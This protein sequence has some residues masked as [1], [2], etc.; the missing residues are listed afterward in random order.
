MRTMLVTGIMLAVVATLLAPGEAMATGSLNVTV[1]P[2]PSTAGTV[3][4]A[5]W[6]LDNDGTWRNPSSTV[7]GLAAG[8]HSVKMKVLTGWLVVENRTVTIVDGEQTKL[9]VTYVKEG[10]A[11]IPSSCGGTWENCFCQ[12]FTDLT[13][14]ETILGLIPPEYL[15]MLTLLQPPNADVNGTSHVDLT[16]NPTPKKSLDVPSVGDPKATYILTTSVKNGANGHGTISPATGPQNAGATITLTATPDPGGY[17]VKEWKGTNDNESTALTNTVTMSSDKTVEVEFYIPPLIQVRGNG[18]TDCNAELALIAAL[19]QNT[20]LDLT[21][22]GGLSHA[23]M[24]AAWQTNMATLASF[25]GSYFG[26]VGFLLPSLPILL[27][28]FLSIGDGS[29]HVSADPADPDTLDIFDVAGSG[30]FI[31]ILMQ[32]LGDADIGADPLLSSLSLYTR[33]GA[34]DGNPDGKDYLSP[35]GDADGDGATNECEYRAYGVAGGYVSKA[36]DPAQHPSKAECDALVPVFRFGSV[37]GGGWRPMGAPIELSVTVIDSVAPVT[38][39]W[40]KNGELLLGATLS[41]YTIADPQLTDSAS[42]SCE[43][44][45]SSP[46]TINTGS[47]PVTVV[48]AGALPVASMLGGAALTAAVALLGGIRLSRRMRK[49]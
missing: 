2:Y 25:V 3:T 17:T 11:A 44:T 39:Q 5:G 45:D 19:L 6:M 30:G 15:G 43:A 16:P 12:A 1:S 34:A 49:A 21:S 10:A 23:K 22:T 26:T 35:K 37:K 41:T 4:G 7:S 40:Y 8:S 28:G 20:S 47:I 13:T 38:Y 46:K 32:M 24:L 27:N 14:N 42:F 29:F 48:E 33:Y 31:G 36:L 18:M 9:A